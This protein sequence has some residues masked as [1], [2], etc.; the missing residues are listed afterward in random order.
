M[1]I[2]NSQT[3]VWALLTVV[4]VVSWLIARNGGHAHVV[5]ATVTAVVILIAAFKTHLVI[6]RFMEVR[7]A[8]RWLKVTTGSWLVVLFTLLL[9]FYFVAL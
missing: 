5:N 4:T 2:R 9:T 7:H 1:Y 6:W 8:P 3:T